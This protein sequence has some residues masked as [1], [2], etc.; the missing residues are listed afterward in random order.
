MATIASQEKRE[1]AIAAYESGQGSQ[2]QIAAMFKVNWSTLKRW[3]AAKRDEGRTAPLPRG[4]NPAS[5]LGQDLA[6][7]D[8]YVE[9]HVDA[10]LEDLQEAFSG[11]VK[12]SIATIHNTLKRLG[13]V[14]K[15]SGY[16]RM[17]ETDP[18]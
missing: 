3:L 16:M 10:S 12:C 13:W 18:T 4:H 7:L 8:A 15:K 2:T 11:H 5:F 9:T 1:L 14:R 17:S 6:A